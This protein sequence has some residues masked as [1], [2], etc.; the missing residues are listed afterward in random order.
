M[1]EKFLWNVYVDVRSMNRLDADFYKKYYQYRYFCKSRENAG[2][3]NYRKSPQFIK[4]LDELNFSFEKISNC[5]G[6]E[7]NLNGE[8]DYPQVAYKSR[9]VTKE[10]K[11]VK[12]LYACVADT[13]ANKKIPLHDI[14]EFLPLFSVGT[15]KVTNSEKSIIDCVTIESTILEV[16]E[17]FK[18]Y[19]PKMGEFCNVEKCSKLVSSL[20]VFPG[21]AISEINFNSLISKEEIDT[22]VNGFMEMVKAKEEV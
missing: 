7:K 14:F 12:V 13:T 2:D 5:A 16:V 8:Y 6:K 19:L 1:V 17:C 18:K 4:M 22:C 21:D 3:E 11:K 15:M 10:G 9:I 20:C